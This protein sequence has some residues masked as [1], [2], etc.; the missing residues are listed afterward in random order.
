MNALPHRNVNTGD[1]NVYPSLELLQQHGSAKAVVQRMP[2]IIHH[3]VVEL[4]ATE[5]SNAP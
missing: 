5:I 3:N 4:E 1:K 2:P